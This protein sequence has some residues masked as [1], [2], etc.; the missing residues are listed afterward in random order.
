M[1]KYK[2]LNGGKPYTARGGICH[3]Q[4]VRIEHLEDK[5]RQKSISIKPKISC[6]MEYDEDRDTQI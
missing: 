4:H 6:T 5:N 2:L 1:S 3:I